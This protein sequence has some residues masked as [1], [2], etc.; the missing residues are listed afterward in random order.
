MRTVT[1][2]GRA[3]IL[4]FDGT[5]LY[6]GVPTAVSNELAAKLAERHDVDIDADELDDDNEEVD[7]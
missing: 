1:Y 4:D 5:L 3:G 6:N 7:E 2:T